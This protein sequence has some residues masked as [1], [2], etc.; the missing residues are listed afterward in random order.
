MSS[1]KFGI[2]IMCISIYE[3]SSLICMYTCMHF[4]GAE[5]TPFKFRQDL[6]MQHV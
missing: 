4:D 1:N 2:Y 5:L 6:L 3:I